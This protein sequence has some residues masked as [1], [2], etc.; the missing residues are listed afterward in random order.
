MIQRERAVDSGGQQLLRNGWANGWW[1]HTCPMN[2]A[3][4]VRPTASAAVGAVTRKPAGIPAT[5][6]RGHREMARGWRAGPMAL[7]RWTGTSGEVKARGVAAAMLAA[8]VPALSGCGSFFALSIPAA[9]PRQRQQKVLATMSLSPIAPRATPHINGY[10]ISS[11][12]F[13]ALDLPG[14]AIRNLSIIPSGDGYCYAE[15]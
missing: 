12:A 5:I 13:T 6:A 2:Q 7:V 10:S 8:V 4:I 11:G 9:G 15:Q 14:L 3:K 1:R